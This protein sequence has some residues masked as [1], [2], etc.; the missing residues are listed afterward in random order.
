MDIRRPDAPLPG[1]GRPD[2]A[3]PAPDAVVPVSTGKTPEPV[4][5]PNA[6]GGH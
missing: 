4:L 5:A 1:E 2:P 3:L 6:P